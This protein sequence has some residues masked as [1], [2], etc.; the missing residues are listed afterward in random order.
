MSVTR[1]STLQT[2]VA[3]V[4]L[5][6]CTSPIESNGDGN[7]HPQTEVTTTK[8]LAERTTTEIDQYRNEVII[9]NFRDV[10]VSLRLT[11]TSKADEES[12]FSEQFELAEGNTM[13]AQRIYPDVAILDDDAVV[14]VDVSGGP[15]RTYDWNATD[16]RERELTIKITDDGI[17][18]EEA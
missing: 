3:A 1:R 4:G 18:F 5:A 6:G 8:T 2:I 16:D 7:S 11:I 17:L 10:T 15:T 13:H 12:E 9:E 14:R